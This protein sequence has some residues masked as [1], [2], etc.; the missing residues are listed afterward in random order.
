ME[1]KE[2]VM[3]RTINQL[4][5]VL[6]QDFNWALLLKLLTP[7]YDI[8]EDKALRLIKKHGSVLRAIRSLKEKCPVCD[9]W[10]RHLV[11]GNSEEVKCERC[12]A[13]EKLKAQ[14]N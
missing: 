3:Q 2:E 9:N 1:D 6:C 8:V 14:A 4:N 11:Y 12:N 5:D 7:D 13:R 10:V